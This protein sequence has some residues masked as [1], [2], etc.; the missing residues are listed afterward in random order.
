MSGRRHAATVF[1]EPCAWPPAG[2]FLLSMRGI[3]C[4]HATTRSKCFP[5]SA[6]P[7]WARAIAPA[8]FAFFRRAR[9]RFVFDQFASR[10]PLFPAWHF[11]FEQPRR[12][13]FSNARALKKLV[14]VRRR[15]K[16]H[17]Q[18]RQSHRG[19]FRQ[20]RRAGAAHGNGR[21][22]QRQIHFREKRFDDGLESRAR[23]RRL[24][25]F[26]NRSRR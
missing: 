18:R 24:S 10:P 25:P 13:G 4:R 5:Q 16:R 12:A 7:P 11:L 14:I 3:S 23:R 8:R 6:P 22:A 9:G 26:Q 2:T 15:R 1:A 20:R 17:E 21:R 19:D